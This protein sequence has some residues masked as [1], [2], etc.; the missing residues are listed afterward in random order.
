MICAVL[1]V[2]V[3]LGQNRR[4]NKMDGTK[5]QY[6]AESKEKTFQAADEHAPGA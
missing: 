2:F 1:C 4:L 3:V 6:D 5:E